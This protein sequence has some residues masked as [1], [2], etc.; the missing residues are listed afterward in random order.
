QGLQRP[1]LRP[2]AR[3][4]ELPLS[5]AQQRLWFLEQLEPG[6]PTYHI[7]LAMRLEGA[8]DVSALER[9]FQELVHRHESLRTTFRSTGTEAIQV[10]HAEASLPLPLADLSALPQAQQEA[11][12]RRL[13]EEEAQRPFELTR[14]P[15]LRVTLLKL[16]DTQHVLL[17]TMHH[18]VSDGWSMGVLIREVAALYQ[19]F[20]AG[21]PSPLPALPVQ[22]ADYAAWQR[23]WLQ[24]DALE[25]QLAYWRQHLTGAP[26]VLELPT[27]RPRPAVQS[28]RGANL[29]V[30]LPADLS[31]A[32][33][34]LAQRE[35]A[36]PFMV[37]LAAF[38][39][40]LSRYSGQQDIT[41][42]SPIAGRTHA[43]TEGLIGFF[44]N[45]LVLRTRLEGNPS[46]REL[47]G[48][49]RQVALGAYAH[50]DI[51]FEKLVEEL[52]P[53]RSLS[54]SPLFQVMLVLQNTPV[55]ALSTAEGTDASLRMHSL[56]VEGQTA[57]FD[58]TLSLSETPEGFTGSLQYNT[59]LFESA[60]AA[61]MVEHLRVLL[62][63]ATSNPELSLSA[64]PLLTEAERQQVLVQ[65]N[66]TQ[67][68]RPW[69]G[70][71]HE[72][73]E[74]QAAR[75]PQAVAVVYEDGQLTFSELDR[76]ANQLAHALRSRGVGPE[77][78][79]ALCMERS[80]DMV[81]GVL[82]ILKAGGAYVPMDPA[83]PAQRLAFM[84]Q[85]SRARLV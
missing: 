1:D 80:L 57:K 72:L 7:P 66:D 45:T 64:L 11:E 55:S 59:D 78:R 73:I 18:I 70:C 49:V 28:H 20:T 75:A 50:Q 46:F 26:Q 17:L 36:T 53:Q 76:R 69:A 15:L 2:V 67:A 41:V 74:A 19:A 31:R 63:A 12:V 38:N 24:G 8:L 16:A 77:V 68:E 32:V 85:D 52:K 13:A 61:R 35:G 30:R 27:D 39:A 84:L 25:T 47:I 21:Q 29:S 3:T 79:V 71:L 58:L 23:N 43:D 65:W 34:A 40:V 42:G 6:L 4:G 60:T 33:N 10:I 22:Y 37:L 83:Y 81:V 14:G 82:G 56:G 51:P 48:R 44:I 54:Y 5:F 62:Q 9:A